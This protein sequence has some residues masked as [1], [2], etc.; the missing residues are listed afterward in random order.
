MGVLRQDD[1]R[2]AIARRFPASSR[3]RVIRRS[4]IRHASAAADRTR[5]R[6]LSNIS[7]GAAQA[8]VRT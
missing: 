3:I 8:T 2:P 1:R 4:T 6:A 7:R 5:L